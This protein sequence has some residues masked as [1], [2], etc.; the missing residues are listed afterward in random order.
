[1]PADASDT[2]VVATAAAASASAANAAVRAAVADVEGSLA[3]GRGARSSRGY[4]RVQQ[5]T[6]GEDEEEEEGVMPFGFVQLSS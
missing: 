4:G 6:G 3:Q 5:Q 1:M 2:S